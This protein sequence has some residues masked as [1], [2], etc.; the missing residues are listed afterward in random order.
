MKGDSISP[1]LKSNLEIDVILEKS[2]GTKI[3]YSYRKHM[4]TQ[5]E[6]DILSSSL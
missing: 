5:S 4:T 3:D 1:L 2:H 6:V